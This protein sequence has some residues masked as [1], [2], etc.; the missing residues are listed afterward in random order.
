MPAKKMANAI[1]D[2]RGHRKHKST[3][4]PKY[5]DYTTR[6]QRNNRNATSRNKPNKK[7]LNMHIYINKKYLHHKQHT[8]E[9]TQIENR[10]EIC[11]TYTKAK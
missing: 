11:K 7:I 9:F 1:A 2:A 6:S 10:H 3:T 8:K 5:A 4:I